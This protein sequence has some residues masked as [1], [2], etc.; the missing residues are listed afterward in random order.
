MSTGVTIDPKTQL[1]IFRQRPKPS[2]ATAGFLSSGFVNGVNSVAALVILTLFAIP[3]CTHAAG[4]D[5]KNKDHKN[6]VFFQLSAFGSTASDIPSMSNNSAGFGWV[7]QAG[8]RMDNLGLFLECQRDLWTTS[9]LT[10][11]VVNGVLNL[12]FG[13]NYLL[14]SNRV[15]VSAS[16]GTSTLLFDAIFDAAGTTGF[17]VDIHPTT[18]R[19]PVSE[20]IVLELSPFSF[21]LEVPVVT[22]PVLKRLEYRT[23]FGLEVIF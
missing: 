2:V 1:G 17:Y 20:R 22:K 14:F 12:G 16:V 21:T 9:E 13:A 4:E 7:A 10:V 6:D 15:K 19:W 18:L 23:S 11:K 5:H 8:Y 3:L